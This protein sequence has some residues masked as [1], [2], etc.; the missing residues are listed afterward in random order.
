MRAPA[1]LGATR[2]FRICMFRL[3]RMERPARCEANEKS[4]GAEYCNSR[5]RARPLSKRLREMPRHQRRWKKAAGLDVL[6]Q[7]ETHEFHRRQACGCHERRRNILEDYQWQEADAQFQDPL[8]RRTALGISKFNS[9]FRASRQRTCA[10]VINRCSTPG[11]SAGRCSNLLRFEILRQW[12]PIIRLPSCSQVVAL[13]ARE[14]GVIKNNFRSIALLLQLK[15]R[16]GINSRIPVSI[17]PRLHHAFVRSQFHMP[18]RDNSSKAFECSANVSANFGRRRVLDG[19]EPGHLREL[20]CIRER[21]V[22]ALPAHLEE[23]LLM[24]RF[25]GVGNFFACSGRRLMGSAAAEPQCSSRKTNRWKK[26]C[27][28]GRNFSAAKEI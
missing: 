8:D 3:R 2:S 26:R 4:G 27:Q 11:T 21:F 9:N 16:N 12:L 23:D 24:N 15:F 28:P 5:L 20:P 6:L 13:A 10:E 14:A 19:A 22:N 25:G 17:S 18:S 7:H 1:H